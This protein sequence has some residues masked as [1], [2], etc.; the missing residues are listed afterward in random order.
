VFLNYYQFFKL[1]TSLKS[2]EY[3]IFHSFKSDLRR[4]DLGGDCIDIT[5]Y[6]ISSHRV[7]KCCMRGQSSEIVVA[8]LV[9]QVGPPTLAAHGQQLVDS[10]IHAALVAPQHGLD[11]FVFEC[12]EHGLEVGHCFVKVQI[13]GGWPVSCGLGRLGC[14]IH[15]LH[16]AELC[17]VPKAR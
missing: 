5:N 6:N 8:R 1:K 15:C 17:E 4:T 2:I 10:P 9:E 16:H 14:H 11:H 12:R 3:Q 7:E 13:D